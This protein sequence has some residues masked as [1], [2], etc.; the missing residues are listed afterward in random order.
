MLKKTLL[1]FLILNF[2]GT[3]V[4]ADILQNSA[5]WKFF[6]KITTDAIT[7]FPEVPI[8]NKSIE[9]GILKFG[10]STY[11]GDIK[12]KIK[13]TAMEFLNFQMAQHMRENLREIC[14]TVME[15]TLT[16]MEI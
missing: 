5:V 4:K 10:S 14:F 9:K 11:V 13:L 3:A 16:K 2:C 12:K 8:L 7:N 15:Y 6:S 1:I